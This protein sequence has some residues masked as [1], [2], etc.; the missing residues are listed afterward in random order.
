MQPI[1]PYQQ[2][3]SVSFYLSLHAATLSEKA[4]FSGEVVFVLY[5]PPSLPPLRPL[6]PR[7]LEAANWFAKLKPSAMSVHILM[8]PYPTPGH[9]IPLLDL[10]HKLLHLR[11]FDLAVTVLITPDNLHL[12]DPFLSSSSSSS[13]HCSGPKVLP[14]TEPP[15]PPTPLS[16]SACL[17]LALS[18]WRRV[19]R[20]HVRVKVGRGWRR[21]ACRPPE[22]GDGGNLGG[23][24]RLA[25]WIK[26]GDG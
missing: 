17:R 9:I 26:Q 12:L 7:P 8:Y 6:K 5:P 2:T 16:A 4:F 3:P 22:M 10:A 13:S 20:S 24:A 19:V 11:R 15:A 18:P 14:S 25:D 21:G 23:E 1:A